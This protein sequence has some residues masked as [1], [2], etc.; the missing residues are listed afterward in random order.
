VV[1]TAEKWSK[2]E[3]NIGRKRKENTSMKEIKERKEV[4]EE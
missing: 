2:Q 4:A 1:L 3:R